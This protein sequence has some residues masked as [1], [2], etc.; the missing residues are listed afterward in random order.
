ML[1]IYSKSEEHDYSSVQANLPSISKRIIDWGK[2][3]IKNSYIYEGEGFGRETNIHV[4]VKYGL[5]TDDADEVKKVV[6]GYG[7][8]DIELGEISKFSS[9][10]FDVI[11]IEVKSKELHELNKLIKNELE[12][13]DTHPVYKPHITIAYVQ[14]GNCDELVGQIPFEGEKIK[15][16]EVCFS[17][18]E[19]EKTKIKL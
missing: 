13:T 4:T 7:S 16:S 11:M 19:G 5:H 17:P 3:K 8:F 15:I 12:C 10:D 18:V 1:R 6:T 9:D 2:T 14:K